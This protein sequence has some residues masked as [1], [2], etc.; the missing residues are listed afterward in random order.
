[1]KNRRKNPMLKTILIA[2]PVILIA[3]GI[4]VAMQPADFRI[5]RTATISAPPADVFAQVNDF[6]KWQHWSPWAKLDPAA[7][8][9]F[10]GPAAGT[11]A[12]FRWAGNNQVGEGRMTITESHPSDLIRIELEFL[13]PFKATNTAEFTFKPEGNQTVVSWSMFGKNNFMGKAMGLIMDCD[14]MLGGQFEQGLANMKSVA[15]NGQ[16]TVALQER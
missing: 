10:E 16:Q 3:F 2:V 8:S 7:K 11:G 6:S 13:R 1:M 14:K 15:E 12:R 9:T 5:T 4:V